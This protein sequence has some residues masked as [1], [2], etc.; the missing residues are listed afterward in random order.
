MAHTISVFDGHND[1]LSKLYRD[2]AR[3]FLTE[4]GDGH[5]DLPRMRRGGFAGGFFAVFVP[6]DPE[7]ESKPLLSSGEGYREPLASR[8]K[9]EYA[10]RV[11][12]AQTARLFQLET[13]TNGALR[14]V[15]SAEVLQEAIDR[16]SIAAILHFEG[17]DPI[18][19]DL[20]L[21]DVLHR[22]G[23]RSLGIVWS[24]PNAFGHG[25]PF[26]FP[27]SPDLGPG[28]TDAG[29]RLVKR[30]NELGIIIDVSHLN[31]KGFFDVAA[32]SNAPLVASHC[33]V[34]ALCKASRNLVD[35]QLDAIA[36]SRGIVGVNLAVAFLRPDG[37]NFAETP[38]AVALDHIDYLVERMGIDHVGIGS[39]FD[40]ALISSEIGD[41]SGMPKI[42]QGLEAR[43][44]SKQDVEKIARNNWLRV[45]RRTWSGNSDL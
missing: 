37:K 28:L 23:L 10:Q 5:M 31:E 16:G 2:P 34:H 39:D 29:R 18:D 11:A 24:R 33:S 30:C 41:V 35:R 43:G 14:V 17:A 15:T 4:A 44:Y 40:G 7:E 13:E 6:Q 3:P 8:L 36:E 12:F 38:I 9:L 21:L 42:V 32:L 26:E 19:E 45:I 22:A 27:S 20:H 25:V 1:L